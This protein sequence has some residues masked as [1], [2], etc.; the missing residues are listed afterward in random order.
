MSVLIQ[1][2]I[3]IFIETCS[4]SLFSCLHNV[5]VVFFFVLT[6]TEK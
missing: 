2:C 3:T 6:L 5:V 1:V 4:F